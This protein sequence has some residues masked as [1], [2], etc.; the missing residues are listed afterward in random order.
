M[1]ARETGVLGKTQFDS[2]GAANRQTAATQRNTFRRPIGT[3]DEEVAR[4]VS[5]S[6]GGYYSIM[7]RDRILPLPAPEFRVE[8]GKIVSD[9]ADPRFHAEQEMLAAD[10]DVRLDL[11]AFRPPGVGHTLR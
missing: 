5:P 11:L 10:F 8:L 1:L 6:L 4:H 9:V 7:P 2:T 3:L